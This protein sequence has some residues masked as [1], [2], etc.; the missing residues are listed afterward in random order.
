M[1]H[2]HVGLH[3]TC[4]YFFPYPPLTG[5]Y[6]IN[7]Q[8]VINESSAPMLVAQLGALRPRAEHEFFFAPLGPKIEKNY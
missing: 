3:V 2:S 5:I 6:C 4:K 8:T 7:V 1:I